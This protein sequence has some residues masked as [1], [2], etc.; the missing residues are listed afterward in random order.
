MTRATQTGS[1]LVK[2][3]ARDAA[4]ASAALFGTDG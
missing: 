4:G 3:D 2:A 1:G